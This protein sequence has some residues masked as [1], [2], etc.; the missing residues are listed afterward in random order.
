MDYEK[1]VLEIGREALP[2]EA[3]KS[4]KDTDALR[5]RLLITVEK[6]AR[7]LNDSQCAAVIAWHRSELSRAG[8]ER[9]EQLDVA[10]LGFVNETKARVK[11]EQERDEARRQLATIEPKL[12]EFEEASGEVQGIDEENHH[13]RL[14]VKELESKLAAVEAARAKAKFGAVP[15]SEDAIMRLAGDSGAGYVELWG[16]DRQALC[17]EFRR[18]RNVIASQSAE[19]AQ[20]RADL[21]TSKSLA[22]EGCAGN[23]SEA[24]TALEHAANTSDQYRDAVPVLAELDRRA[25]MLVRRQEVIVA[26]QAELARLRSDLE[27]SRSMCKDLI[28]N[29]G[30]AMGA[31][32]QRLKAENEELKEFEKA[33]RAAEK[34]EMD[35]HDDV[36]EP[37]SRAI[38]ALDRKRASR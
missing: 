1:H 14:R 7:P 13:L 25:T 29:A 38:R 10:R 20:L 11:A 26:L 37:V 35:Y 24:R 19:L 36:A 9:D 8:G 30:S 6:N 31:E 4:N 33:V 16:A 2:M 23:F 5:E 22:K 21:E 18:L 32:T 34:L 3:P 28:E 15:G 27:T 17:E 12:R